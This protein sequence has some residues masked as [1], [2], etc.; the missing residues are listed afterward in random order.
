MISDFCKP[1]GKLIYIRVL[2][3]AGLSQYV[4]FLCGRREADVS[5]GFAVGLMD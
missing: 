1:A 3:L 5:D 2:L 4:A